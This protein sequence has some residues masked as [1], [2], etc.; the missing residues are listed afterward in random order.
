MP[1]LIDPPK[2]MSR[3]WSFPLMCLCRLAAAS[4]CSHIVCIAWDSGSFESKPMSLLLLL[5]SR[6]FW[7][8]PRSVHA[9]TH[10]PTVAVP[11]LYR[12]STFFFLGV[13][14]GTTADK[15]GS[16]ASFC[17]LAKIAANFS[18][19]CCRCSCVCCGLVMS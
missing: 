2:L 12:A 8:L 13:K 14:A 1:S 10:V 5:M 11:Y 7:S 6:A 3:T 18:A 15:V 17:S 16:F 19:T 4:T 9:S